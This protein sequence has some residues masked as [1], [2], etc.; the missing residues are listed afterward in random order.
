L[1]YLHHKN[2]YAVTFN[3]PGKLNF[4]GLGLLTDFTFI[5]KYGVAAIS[6]NNMEA[7]PVL[8]DSVIIGKLDINRKIKKKDKHN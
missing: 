7:D 1:K 5:Y 4:Y 2:L 8:R 6:T 3:N